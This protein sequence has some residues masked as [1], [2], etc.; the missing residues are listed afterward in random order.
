MTEITKTLWL[1]FAAGLIF[2][3]GYHIA[4]TSHKAP[5]LSEDLAQYCTTHPK[6]HPDCQ[7]Y[8]LQK[9]DSTTK[10]NLYSFNSPQKPKTR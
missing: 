7:A 1:Y 8:E 2:T 3:T 5:H 4:E 9:N 10:N 6:F